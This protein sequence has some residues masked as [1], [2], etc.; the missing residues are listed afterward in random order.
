MHVIHKHV[1]VRVCV[2]WNEVAR[3]RSQ[4]A[5]FK[6][7]GIILITR[8][9]QPVV[10]LLCIIEKL[11]LIC[12]EIFLITEKNVRSLKGKI[13]RY[14]ASRKC[15]LQKYRTRVGR[16]RISW[17]CARNVN[18][19]LQQISFHSFYRE[20]R[21]ITLH[22]SPALFCPPSYRRLAFV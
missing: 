19:S 2:G 11:R 9:S 1:C 18:V 6:R 10:S 21:Q 4:F 5:K 17:R 16:A 13:S 22:Q 14:N 20:P 8:C 12:F 7:N 3:Y 15:S